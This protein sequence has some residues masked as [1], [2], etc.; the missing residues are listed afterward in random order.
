MLHVDDIAKIPILSDPVKTVVLADSNT[1]ECC[2]PLLNSP[3]D[4]III[5]AGEVN[6]TL[7][8]CQY[9]WDKLIEL[10]A[11]RS[12][13]L[14][15]LGG[16]MVCDLGAFAA[17]TYLRGIKY[18]LL[19]TTL[20]AMVDASVGGKCGVDYMHLKNYIGLFSMPE[21]IYI[22]RRFLDTLP[23]EE[24]INGQMEMIKHGLIASAEHF[25]RLV[26]DSDA[27]K[28]LIEES[29]AIKEYHTT[30]DF[31]EAGIRKRLN[32]GH[33]VGHAIES[34]ALELGQPIA[35]GLAVG[36]GML[37][38]AFISYES[39]SLEKQELNRI[40]AHLS[41]L[42]ARL[43]SELLQVDKLLYYINLDKKKRSDQILFTVLTC[44][45]NAQEGVH[46]SEEVIRNSISYIQS[47]A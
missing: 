3:K 43:S 6:K 41:P 5:P 39:W 15:C 25:N 46:V 10:G 2:L 16:G 29:I 14:I 19:P 30:K 26:S 32:Y 34:F 9:V 42:V 1:A 7:Q 47:F 4:V 27:W 35:H 20:L 11:D 21:E 31:N 44:I 45:G 38:E 40:E 23:K 8:T 37:A 28:S 22:D 33:T 12:T 17:A 24:L 18:Y 36:V 13:R